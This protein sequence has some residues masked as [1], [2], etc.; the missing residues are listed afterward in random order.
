MSRAQEKKLTAEEIVARIE[1]SFEETNNPDCPLVHPRVVA[2]STIPRDLRILE[3]A[4]QCVS[5]SLSAHGSAIAL[6]IA[7]AAVHLAVLATL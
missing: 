3:A 7:P 2:S 4:R 5:P 1:T 6:L